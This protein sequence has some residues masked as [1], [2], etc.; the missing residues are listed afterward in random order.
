M[1]EIEDDLDEADID[2]VP[3]DEYESRLHSEPRE[4]CDRFG[5]AKVI[6]PSDE[7]RT[8][9]GQ[10]YKR[11][12]R[13]DRPNASKK[14]RC[15]DDDDAT[16]PSIVGLNWN[17]KFCARLESLPFYFQV[18]EFS[19]TVGRRVYTDEDAATEAVKEYILEEFPDIDAVSLKNGT[20]KV[21]NRVCTLRAL[22]NKLN[23][24]ST[25]A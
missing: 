24:E 4:N 14:L 5:R 1:S 23:G 22:F 18:E 7:N 17:K 16:S 25:D 3:A 15:T 6:V 21:I 20:E 10:T 9:T 8:P 19:F 12:I 11:K 2:S 13:D